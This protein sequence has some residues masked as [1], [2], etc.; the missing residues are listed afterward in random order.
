MKNV[1]IVVL[2]VMTLI[3]ATPAHAQGGWSCVYDFT[4]GKHGWENN[5]TTNFSNYITSQGWGRGTANPGWLSLTSPFISGASTI[6]SITFKYNQDGGLSGG[7][8]RRATY[9]A[10]GG[11]G[12]AQVLTIASSISYDVVSNT[13]FSFTSRYIGHALSRNTALPADL[14]LIGAELH[15]TGAMPAVC[16]EPEP[17]DDDLI[18][19]IASAN[20]HYWGQQGTVTFSNTPGLP[21]HAP[22]AGTV[23]M[24]PVNETD[25]V[26]LGAGARCGFPFP[27][28]APV[29]TLDDEL[30]GVG[31]IPPRDVF[32][33]EIAGDDD[34]I[35]LIAHS[36]DL[37]LSNGQEVTAGCVLGVT[38]R[39]DS[40]IWQ[41]G[42]TETLTGVLYMDFGIVAHTD[43]EYTLDAPDDTP[44]NNAPELRGCLGD[45]TL[46]DANRWARTAGVLF[47][48]PGFVLPTTGQISTTMNLAPERLPSMNVILRKVQS[49]AW[50]TP[51][52]SV[53]TIQL[54]NTVT[55]LAL[56]DGF[57]YQTVT[58]P[59]QTHAPD[60]AGFYTVLVRNDSEAYAVWVHSICVAL[61]DDLT[62]PEPPEP[63]EP[64]APIDPTPDGGNVTVTSC[65]LIPFPEGVAL[66]TWTSWAWAK[67]EQFFHCE[68]MPV[69]IQIRTTITDFYRTFS[70]SMRWHMASVQAGINW[71]GNSVLPYLAGYLTNIQPSQ[72]TV[73]ENCDN[74]WCALVA[75][76]ENII[77][78]LWNFIFGVLGA[79]VD[80]IKAVV[81][82]LIGLF[83]NLLNTALSLFNIA[84]LAFGSLISAYINATPIAPPGFA[85]CPAIPDSSNPLCL[86]YWVLEH[87]VFT[88]SG[89]LIIPVMTGWFAVHLLL[90][91]IS[92]IKR[93]FVQLGQ[94]S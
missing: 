70:W 8:I 66:N 9:T 37:Y 56:A 51:P 78:P 30:I 71:L 55:T 86:L 52:Y 13:S 3:V 94:V 73:N 15:G 16:N 53:V 81:L 58:I 72:I 36:V 1:A 89:A 11:A 64:V 5:G 54:G 83:F 90:Y 62:P 61:G 47:Q 27:E 35:A 22:I 33:I 2:L 23:T 45:N 19:P 60:I 79:L 93:V 91:F 48:N 46:A 77:A 7:G 82:G 6:T 4:T 10:R 88:H 20:D 85:V 18:K 24:R 26:A 38:S 43:R 75:V 68:L 76:I 39:I 42:G 74:F 25:C 41:S 40:D 92:E 69:L 17:P 84:R 80:V 59:A 31:Y 57:D 21:V 63:P 12:E 65:A 29:P 87:T 28:P 34:T 50:N 49:P 44:C 32:Y 14:R 67:L